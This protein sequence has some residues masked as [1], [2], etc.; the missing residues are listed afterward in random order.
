MPNL[1]PSVK[2]EGPLITERTELEPSM[3]GCIFGFA[4]T[5]KTFETGALMMIDADLILGLPVSKI[6][7]RMLV[8]TF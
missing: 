4:M 2:R 6:S 1:E 5:S 7:A 8:V 3:M